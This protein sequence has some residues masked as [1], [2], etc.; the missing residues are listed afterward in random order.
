[1]I[2]SYPFY[3][4]DWLQS[5]AVAGMTAEQRGVYRELLDHC[6]M[7][8]DLP[9]D[10]RLL[11]KLARCE[12]D[13]WQRAWPVVRHQFAERDGRLHN[14]KVDAC[15]PKILQSKDDRKRGAQ[16][17]NEI[18]RS[19][20]S[21]N[22]ER[23]AERN[24][25]RSAERNAERSAE[26][27]AEQQT[28]ANAQRT[29]PTSTSTSTSTNTATLCIPTPADDT[30]PPD[31]THFSVELRDRFPVNRRGTLIQVQQAIAVEFSPLLNGQLENA[32]GRARRNLTAYLAS[33]EVKKGICYNAARWVSEGHW[34][35][36]VTLPVDDDP[37]AA[38]GGKV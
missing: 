26:R 34:Q 14:S 36:D 15:R 22:A 9:T 28:Q 4:P 3:V 24:A 17:T 31:L 27:D 6:W 21:G 18:R 11:R 7:A 38:L 16:R 12:E 1:V 10:E 19:Q 33:A 20:R 30:E 37:F 2:S 29:P 23:S 35:D 5:E 25:E 8:G 13:E 32:M